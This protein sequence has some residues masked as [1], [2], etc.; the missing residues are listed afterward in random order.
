[1]LHRHRVAFVQA[2]LRISH[3]ALNRD[4]A[5]DAAEW[6]DDNPA[7][8][9]GQP[10]ERINA[11]CKRLGTRDCRF[12]R[13]QFVSGIEKDI[14]G[15]QHFLQIFGDFLGSEHIVGHNQHRTIQI[16]TERRYEHLA[17]RTGE[18]GYKLFPHARR[19]A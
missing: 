3:N 6:N 16:S 9:L 8:P 10:N 14:A 19:N 1:M 5:A 13:Y 4:V 12:G 17:G 7:K 15:R 18:A 11:L 2:D